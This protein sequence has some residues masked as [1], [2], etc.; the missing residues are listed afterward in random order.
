MTAVSD[1]SGLTSLA[2]AFARV[3]AKGA[4]DSL[5]RGMGGLHLRKIKTYRVAGI[6]GEVSPVSVPLLLVTSLFAYGRRSL[7]IHHR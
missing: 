2:C 4:T 1:F 6:V 5:D 7:L 3:E